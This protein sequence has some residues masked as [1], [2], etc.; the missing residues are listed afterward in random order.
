[1]GLV[2]NVDPGALCFSFLFR[3]RDQ[4]PDISALPSREHFP[5]EFILSGTIIYSI[6]QEQ[7][8][9]AL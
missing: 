9:V 1:M 5:R 6:L 3:L 4:A 7:V 8:E 2:S